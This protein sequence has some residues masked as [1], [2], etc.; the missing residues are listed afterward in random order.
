MENNQ[1]PIIESATGGFNNTTAPAP[2]KKSRQKLIIIVTIAVL[3]VVGI[4]VLMMVVLN[5]KQPTVAKP[6]NTETLEIYS[7]LDAEID[8]D[9]INDVVKNINAGAEIWL[10]D[11][12][13]TIEMKGSKEEFISFYYETD[14]D[15][16]EFD[17]LE[18]A[19]DFT[20]VALRDEENSESISCAK[21][22][23]YYDGVE[24]HEFESKKE[25]IEAYLK[26][27]N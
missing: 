24:V 17:D 6:K 10:D 15:D 18:V 4:I 3:L 21:V 16:G 2:E 25:A 26:S 1:Y 22:C 5:Q 11:D 12:Y 8:M 13:G 9:K 19:H 20:Y 27:D 7:E 14:D 23:Y